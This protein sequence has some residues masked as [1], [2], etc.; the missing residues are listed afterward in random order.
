MLNF[1]ST[2]WNN[3]QAVIKAYLGAIKTLKENGLG[4][5]YFGHFLDSFIQNETEIKL[6]TMHD[7]TDDIHIVNIQAPEDIEKETNF[8]FGDI[9][10]CVKD[11]SIIVSK[12][13]VSV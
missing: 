3:E 2:E 10:L 1:T 7:L 8:A 12:R 9:Q 11:P 6:V 4:V 5:F 13:E